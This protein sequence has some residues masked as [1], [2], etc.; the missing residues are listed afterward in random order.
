MAKTGSA[1]RVSWLTIATFFNLVRV[2]N[3]SAAFNRPSRNDFW[4][5]PYGSGAE[6]IARHQSAADASFRHAVIGIGVDLSSVDANGQA[7]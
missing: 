2:H 7:G 5:R 4:A 3:T 6:G 1:R